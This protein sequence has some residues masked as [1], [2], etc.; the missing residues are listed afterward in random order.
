MDSS[1]TRVY[2]CVS[3][4]WDREWYETFQEYRMWLVET[5]D[6]LLDL[7][8]AEP[9]FAHF[10][11][12]GQAVVLEDYL[13]IR[14][15]NR[16]RLVALMRAGRISAGPWYVLPDEWL[17]SGESYIRNIQLGRATCRALGAEPM[18][19]GYTPDQFGHIAALPMILTGLGIPA[20]LV[21]RGTN[22]EEFPPAF[23]WRGP[24]G[25]R[26]LT[27][28][29]F[30][31]AAY[32]W[33]FYKVRTMQGIT[34]FDD[35]AM[36][37]MIED[38]LKRE[39]G[40]IQAPAMLVL[41]GNDHQIPGAHMVAL[42]EGVQATHPE[43]ELRWDSLEAYAAELGPYADRFPEIEGELRRVCPTPD[44]GPQYLIAHVVSSRYPIKRANDQCQALLERWVEP[45]ALYRMLEGEAPPTAYI[46]EAWRYLIQ[47]HPHD[48]ICGCSIDQ[49]HRDMAYRFAQCE[50]I[51]EGL[52]RRALA[53]STGATAAPAAPE[54]LAVHNP[55]PWERRGVFEL[56]VPIPMDWP[57]NYADGLGSGEPIRKFAL[58]GPTG[59][60]LPFQLGAI[61]R[62][63][64]H[65]EVGPDGRPVA[66]VSDICRVAVEMTAPAAGSIC[67]RVEPTPKAVRNWGTLRTQPRTA[68][69]GPIT[70]AL[71]ADG[72]ARLTH[73]AS[74]RAYDGL[75]Q[76]EDRGDAG[77]GWTFGPLVHDEIAITPGSRVTTGIEEDGDLRT[78]LRAEREF[79]LP[80]YIRT[81]GS[82][83]ADKGRHRAHERAVLRVV[84]R[85]VIERGAPYVRVRTTIENTVRDHRFRVLFPTGIDTDVSF[86]ETPFAVVERAID[87]PDAA[88]WAHERENAE[89]PFTSFF[90][91][92]DAQ[93]GLAVVAP[94][95]LHEYEATRTAE[96][97]LALTLFRSTHK[98]VQTAGE[99]DGLLLGEM[100][101]EYL[102]YPFAGEPDYTAMARLAVETAA[103]VRMHLCSGALA[104]GSAMRLLHGEVVVTAVKPAEDGQGGVVRVWN[105]AGR[106][107]RDALWLSRPIAQAQVCDLA[108]APVS[109]LAPTAEGTLPL[110]VPPRSL[111]TV[112]F[113]WR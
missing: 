5:I 103:G 88:R 97:A 61:E 14:P 84:D 6:A 107:V 15:E 111:L 104:E 33:L 39:L 44:R 91:L 92:A 55:L 76:Y 70:F 108:E 65:K 113:T 66:A 54:F 96:R 12:D 23:V 36:R 98:T 73:H 68:C 27:H 2:Y 93:G 85:F 86:A 41:D 46:E 43:L 75:F 9:K 13:R 101:F 20:G 32:G 22:D 56:E 52:I 57:Q 37:D 81:G 90:G 34:Q 105:P 49:V 48:S 106:P 16:E 42:F 26:M 95:G 25:S 3:T 110:E 1:A 18:N 89:K 51:A 45:L 10:H 112:R 102:L 62:G 11:L 38:Y 77:D 63:K 28:K 69:S 21:W 50:G 24:D 100:A 99:P 80:A 82:E 40:R 29:L 30:D 47:N 94:F 67:L 35:P 4:H 60:E 72:S 53:A 17:I 79:M 109:E 74:G 71:H 59:E 31:E 78:V 19:F 58:V 7:M 83:D 87:A 64:V 8:E